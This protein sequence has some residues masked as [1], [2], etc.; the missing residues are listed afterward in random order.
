[1][2]E[3]LMKIGHDKENQVQLT[4][5][6]VF[7][8][9]TT[10]L[11]DSCIE[12][13]RLLMHPDPQKR[14]TSEKFLRHPWTQ[15]LTASWTTMGKTH[16]ELKTFWQNRFRMEVMKKF[17]AKLSHI[18]DSKLLSEKDLADIFQAL[19]L[20]GNGVLEL[21]EIQAAF[22]DIGLSAQNVRS[23]FACSDLDGTGVIHFDE[24]K[25]LLNPQSKLNNDEP[26][27]DNPRPGLHVDYLQ[28]R[29]KSH[30][31]KRL[32]VDTTTAMTMADKDRLRKVFNTID[33]EGNGVLDPH[34]IRIFLRSVGEPEAVIS[35]I[36][37]SLD[38]N[39]DGSVS[40]D[41]FL[42]IMVGRKT[43]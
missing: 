28:H 24:F 41:E 12:L 19:D 21:D 32:Q 6:I 15:G 29:F 31:T 43:N 3:I 37:A 1:M 14:M 38:L 23:I 16:D 25:T 34:D 26:G 33:L 27:D 11:S 17:A 22:R 13:M 8:E 4:S 42:M 18:S 36:V 10:G 9:R 40:W 30:I 2:K 20:K 35:R 39:R 7:D 5:E